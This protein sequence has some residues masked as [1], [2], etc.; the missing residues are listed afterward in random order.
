MRVAEYLCWRYEEEINNQGLFP[1]IGMNTA[2]NPGKWQVQSIGNPHFHVSL[3]PITNETNQTNRTEVI[4]VIDSANEDHQRAFCIR[5]NNYIFRDL[6]LSGRSQWTRSVLYSMDYPLP[7]TQLLSE[8][9]KRIFENIY[10]EAW[11]YI[12]GIDIKGERWNRGFSIGFIYEQWRWVIRVAFFEKADI[13]DSGGSAEM[14]GHAIRRVEVCNDSDIADTREF[15][16]SVANC[17]NKHS[18]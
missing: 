1:L 16:R 4:P 14:S 5:D 18:R 10:S 12:D 15:A 8:R 17:L 3:L 9:H 2:I 11:S 13:R 6:F 7:G